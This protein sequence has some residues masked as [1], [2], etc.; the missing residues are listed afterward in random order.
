MAH[1]KRM[2]RLVMVAAVAMVVMWG[3]MASAMSCGDALS[4]MSPCGG[5]LMGMASASLSSLCCDRA[6]S[7]ARSASSPAQ[8][9]AIC[10]C[11][12]E[13]APSLGV[14]PD[15]VKAMLAFCK[16]PLNLPITP[17]IDCSRV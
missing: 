15:R 6:R 4:S 9:K 7:L 17:N 11:F 12:K 3:S 8:R 13:T 16:L 14:K 2:S 1:T 10:E 5:Y